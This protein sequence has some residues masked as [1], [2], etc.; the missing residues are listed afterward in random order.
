MIKLRQATDPRVIHTIVCLYIHPST[1]QNIIYTATQMGPYDPPISRPTNHQYSCPIIL[2]ILRLQ[3]NWNYPKTLS[4]NYFY[5]HRIGFFFSHWPLPFPGSWRWGR[6]P[7]CAFH[8]CARGRRRDL[9]DPAARP[10][11]Q[12]QHE[13]ES[14]GTMGTPSGECRWSLLRAHPGLFQVRIITYAR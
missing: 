10:A 9:R 7:R 3:S 6:I 8:S 1:Y 5:Y 11:G 14:R 2:R 13:T 4:I 12:H